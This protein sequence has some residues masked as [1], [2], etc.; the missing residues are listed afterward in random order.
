MLLGVI[1]PALKRFVLRTG[2]SPV[3]VATAKRAGTVAAKWAPFYAAKFLVIRHVQRED[4]TQVYRM[5][6]KLNRRYV[7]PG[8]ARDNV[9]MSLRALMEAPEMMHEHL[10]ELGQAALLVQGHQ[11]AHKLQN[12]TEPRHPRRDWQ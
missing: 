8:P 1:L 5:L 2:A 11:E 4:I 6:S 3:V 9:Q 12:D 7:K 10:Q